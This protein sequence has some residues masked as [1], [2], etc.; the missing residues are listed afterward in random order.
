M[1]MSRRVTQPVIQCALLLGMLLASSVAMAREAA[2]AADAETAAEI[3][4][5]LH[6]FLANVD[7]GATHDR[8]WASDLVYT[9]AAGA[10]NDK[11]GIMKSFDAT[12]AGADDAEAA[13]PEGSYSAEDIR[14]RPF[15]DSAALTF[16]LVAH[17]ADGTR[18]HYRNSGMFVRRNGRWQAVTWQATR[19]PAE[20]AK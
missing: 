4:G 19:E 3:T 14:V 11:A 10:V 13:E 8:F 1:R 5:L 9:S 7:A 12:S 6:D 15:G 16:R 17:A 2:P 20:P 18:S